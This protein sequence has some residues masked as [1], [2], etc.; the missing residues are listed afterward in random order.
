MKCFMNFTSQE[1]STRFRDKL[2]ELKAFYVEGLFVDINPVFDILAKIDFE[3]D[4]ARYA[5]YL[6][7]ETW[8]NTLLR[9]VEK[10]NFAPILFFLN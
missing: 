2:D 8:A 9:I 3:I 6:D 10:A 7:E 5:A 4:E 1:I